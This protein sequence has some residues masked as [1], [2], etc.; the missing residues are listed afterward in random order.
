MKTKPEVLTEKQTIQEAL[1]SK[2]GNR[3]VNTVTGVAKRL[4]W[5]LSDKSRWVKRTY[6]TEPD[7]TRCCVIGGIKQIDGACE[8]IAA[9]RIEEMRPLGYNSIEGFN[10]SP[11][12]THEV[13]KSFLNFAVKHISK[14]NPPRFEYPKKKNKKK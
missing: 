14:G 4:L 5:L 9:S 2:Y 13:I 8:R 11:R 6:G 1:R 3:K 7:A 10:D 12:T